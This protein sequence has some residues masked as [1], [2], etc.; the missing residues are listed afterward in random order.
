[1]NVAENTELRETAG[2]DPAVRT[3]EEA[4][5]RAEDRDRKL[6]EAEE[7]RRLAEEERDKAVAAMK[8][9][10]ARHRQA[11]EERIREAALHRY[12]SGRGL[13]GE[14]SDLAL[15][16]LRGMKTAG[17]TGEILSADGDGRLTEESRKA[18]DKLFGED[19]AAG[20]DASGSPL[21]ALLRLRS[22]AQTQAGRA[23]PGQEEAGGVRG[24]PVANPPLGMGIGAPSREEILSIRD[25]AERRRAIAE[26]PEVFGL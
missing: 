1:M 15:L 8:E 5:P 24:V 11:E 9:G 21:R 18:L 25:G 22:Q 4:D 17:E 2:E 19:P 7:A 3:A 6:A 20:S 14:A 10:E 26:H 23:L 12:L 16:C 13:D